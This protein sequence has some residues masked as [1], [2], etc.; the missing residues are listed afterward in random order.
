MTGMAQQRGQAVV[1]VAA[2]LPFF[3]AI[4]G[5]T[6]DGEVVWNA[7]RQLQ[8]VADGAA[9]AGAEALDTGAYYG[10]NGQ[11]VA[12]DP[13]A[14]RQQAETYL[15]R[16]ESGARWSVSADSRQV[17]VRL[18]RSVPTSFVRIIGIDAVPLTASAVAEVRHGVVSGTP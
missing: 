12:L 4:I 9:R 7:E 1:W 16:E 11:T 18:R 2:M 10:S 8:G 3:L 17:V 6:V 5:L 14:A 13:S 15:L